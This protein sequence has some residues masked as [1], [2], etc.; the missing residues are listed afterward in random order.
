LS[1]GDRP[2]EYRVSII[3][4]THHEYLNEPARAAHVAA[5]T[6]R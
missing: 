5:E 1:F 4:T 3:D 6:G 2:V